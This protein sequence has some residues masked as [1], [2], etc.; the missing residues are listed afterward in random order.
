MG[1]AR[2]SEILSDLQEFVNVTLQQNN[3]AKLVHLVMVCLVY[4]V[5]P[6]LSKILSIMVHLITRQK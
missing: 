3:K 5:R 6:T 4:L 1:G 2:G